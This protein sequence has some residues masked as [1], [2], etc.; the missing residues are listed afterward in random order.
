MIKLKDQYI[1]SISDTIDQIDEVIRKYG[2]LKY[3]Q[4]K[5]QQ[6]ELKLTKML[7]ELYL[8]RSNIINNINKEY[9]EGVIDPQTWEF[10]PNNK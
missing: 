5:I 7:D 4:I 2:I 3:N 6:E 8:K 1:K 10:I 9:G